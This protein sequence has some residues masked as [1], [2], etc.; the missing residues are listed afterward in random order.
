M[1][2]RFR[3]K[4]F[5]LLVSLSLLVALSFGGI[6]LYL[7]D[8]IPRTWILSQL[9]SSA[10]LMSEEIDPSDVA[11]LGDESNPEHEAARTRLLEQCRRIVHAIDSSKTRFRLIDER[12][13][14]NV[15]TDE[16]DIGRTAVSTDPELVGQTYAISR[17][18]VFSQAWHEPVVRRTPLKS[19]FGE[20]YAAFAPIRDAQ[21]ETVGVLGI[22]AQAHPVR[23][24]AWILL[25]LTVLFVAS[26]VLGAAVVAWFAA[27]WISRPI[28]A[29][30]HAMRRVAEDDLTAR[31][32]DTDRRDEFRR[33]TEGFNEMVA[34]LR[35]RAEMKASLA[36]ASDIQRRLLP[37]P[38]RL[39]GYDLDGRA[40]YCDESGGDYYDF[41]P[42]DP[43][44]VVDGD[45][46]VVRSR[47]WAIALGDVAGHGIGPALLMAWARAAFRVAGPDRRDDLQGLFQ[48]MN[49]HLVRDTPRSRF[50]TLFYAVLDTQTGS[51]HWSSAGHEPAVLIRAGGHVEKLSGTDLPLGLMEDRDYL[52]GEPARLAEGDRL[53]VTSDG[54]T[55]SRAPQGGFFGVDG[56][57]DVAHR[58]PGAS[59]RELCDALI[60]AA[61]DHASDRAIDDDLTTVVLRVTG[62]PGGSSV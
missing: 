44:P 41:I 49:Q 39:R 13:N 14:I 53:I 10:V 47:Y 54:V 61:R 7:E 35:N 24:F 57:V 20:T 42:L 21:G 5:L 37:T 25:G 26:A 9:K 3:T 4:L 29:L 45:V 15:P 33:V 60:Q 6:A 46:D 30:D 8:W 34:A 11:L 40:V 28:T 22:T 18:P 23:N 48:S 59:S 56:M 16:P 12:V 51:L 31:M 55:Q 17:F 62:R 58:H 32:P 43:D 52:P 38:P 36:A 2:V 27:R 50:L 19:E 1:V